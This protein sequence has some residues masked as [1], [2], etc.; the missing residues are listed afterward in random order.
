MRVW[1][2]VVFNDKQ[3]RQFAGNSKLCIDGL[4][5]ADLL[6]QLGGFQPLRQPVGGAEKDGGA[7]NID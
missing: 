2:S 1:A 7:Q 3:N 4:L 5:N 6:E